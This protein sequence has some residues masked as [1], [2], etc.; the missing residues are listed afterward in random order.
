[1]TSIQDGDIKLLKSKV[2]DDVPEGGGGP[3]GNVIGWGQ[4]NDVFDDITEVARAGGQVSIRQLFGA[5]QTGNTEPLMDANIIIDQPATDP[6][7]SITIASCAP[8][9][10][11]SEIATAIANYLIAGTEW[12]GILLGYHVQGQGNIQIFHRVGT[13]APPIGRTLVL[14]Q[15]EGKAT[16]KRQFVRIIRTDSVERTFTFIT[17]SGQIVD[18]Q[19]QVTTCEIGSRLD[20]PFVGSEPNRAFSRDANATRLRDTTV[21]DAIQFYGASPITAAYTLGDPARQ[22]KVSSIYTQL[23]PSSRTERVNLDQRPAAMRSITL[24][25]GLRE[26]TVPITPHTYRF[27]VGQE[28]RGYSWTAI[29]RP[30]PSQGTLVIS[31]MVLGTWY[32]CQDNGAGEL[33]GDAV[34]TINYA[35]GS[36]AVTLPALPDVGSAVLFQ[37][38]ETTGFVNRSST[39]LQVRQPEYVLQLDH[40]PVP[41]TLQIAW[42]SG[43]VLKTATDTVGVLAG[44]AAGEINYA[45]GELLIKPALA[46]WM[47]AQGEFSITYQY[48]TIITKNVTASPDA[49]G[50]AT[51][52]LDS[53]PAAGSVQVQWVTARNVTASSGGSSTGASAGK[54][55]GKHIGALAQGNGSFKPLVRQYG[56]PNGV[57]QQATYSTSTVASSKTQ[58]LQTHLLT[59]DAAGSFGARGTIN[60]AGKS[61]TVKLV[62]LDASTEGYQSSYENSTAFE[63]ATMNGG[64]VSNSAAQ[65]GGQS[66]TVAVS[67]QILAASTVQVTYAESFAS[68]L[69]AV[70]SWQPPA[71]SIDLCPYTSQYVVPGSVQFTWMGHAYIDVDGDIIRDRT[72]SNPGTVAGRMDYAA[73]I[74][75]LND[76]VVTTAAPLVLESLWTSRK[77]WTAGSVFFRTPA[78][79]VAV[80]G[81]TL[82]LSDAQGN[83]LTFT[84][85]LE[86]YFN[87]AQSRGRIDY[88]AGLTEIQFGAFVDVAAL[89]DAERAEWWFDQADVGAV[90][91]GKIWKPL[92]VDPT[93]LRFN[94]VTYVY[95]PL[96]ADIIGMDPV[97]LPSDGRVPVFRNGYYVVVGHTAAL[98]AATLSA[99][100]VINCARTRLSRVWIVGAD[101][102]KIQSGWSVDLDAG[103]LSIADVTGWAQP[104]RV[105]HR[106]EE[107]A[108]VSDVQ[109]NGTLTLTKAL[110]HDFPAGSVV[111]SALYTG[112]IRARVSHLF[113]QA[114]WVDQAWSDGVMG[115][116]A[117]AQ[118]NDTAFPLVVTNAGALS[119]RWVLRFT[120]TTTVEVIGEH[121]GNLG[122]FPIASDIAP[123]NPNTRTDTHSGVPYFTLK[124]GGW[125]GGWAA[126]NIL[127]INTV[128]AMQPFACIRTVQPSEAAGTDYQFGLTVRGDIDRTPQL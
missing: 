18:Y 68:P 36:V 104:V 45:S 113:D 41:G 59:D 114:A 47:D 75:Y 10:K 71:L 42:E 85:D 83:V 72:S 24:A 9:A 26:V 57:S 61:L 96:D 117:P 39:L 48:A 51:I 87:T 90:Q 38:G 109:I 92:P 118:Y 8:F 46:A 67:E 125:G 21:A 17:S 70:Q 27:K 7:V 111:S 4:S 15:D 62:D 50:F 95:L 66:S 64:S 65:K 100:Q 110:S 82:N 105:H 20:H 34:G 76:Y 112:T 56:I 101:G 14:V 126:G 102:Q 94:S 88:Q 3:T 32:T 80:Q 69:T 43:G 11:R 119:E 52:A 86:G 106:I 63:T 53:V 93:T 29:L 77:D 22:V 60:Y 13:S 28:N 79:P 103:L 73:G 121:V 89:T 6:N 33:V 35:N 116:A 2:M 40:P 19:A 99:S 49:A 37:W 115:N 44:D 16:E 107:M 127:R 31:F 78:A 84:P 58:E 30:F 91:A 25:T 1:M 123:I 98:P 97:R 55:S 128:G 120:N 122:S 23:V 74:A 81:I 54:G 108:R 5:V 12:N 124:A